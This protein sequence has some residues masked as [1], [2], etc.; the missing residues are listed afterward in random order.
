MAKHR[1]AEN[2]IATGCIAQ[3]RR[4]FF[5]SERDMLGESD[6]VHDVYRNRE[7]THFS[8]MDSFTGFPLARDS[9]VS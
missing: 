5:I 7:W 4:G 1:Q 6:K 2:S 3:Q 9:K 8:Q